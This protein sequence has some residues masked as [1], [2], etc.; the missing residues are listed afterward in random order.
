LDIEQAKTVAP[1]IFRQYLLQEQ[2]VAADMGTCKS[3]DSARDAGLLRFLF[4]GDWDCDAAMHAMHE[5]FAPSSQ[6]APYVLSVLTATC[7][8]PARLVMFEAPGDA[9]IDAYRRVVLDMLECTKSA[10]CL[11]ACQAV[12]QA[13][14]MQLVASVLRRASQDVLMML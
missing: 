9:D 10:S 8:S 13:S 2:I 11:G 5:L 3:D 6:E 1:A 12:Y 4:R 7:A 14:P